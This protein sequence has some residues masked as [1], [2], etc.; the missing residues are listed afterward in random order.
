MS[1][2]AATADTL[3]QL[4]SAVFRE[5]RFADSARRAYLAGKEETLSLSVPRFTL[6]ANSLP[7][8]FATNCHE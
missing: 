7:G 8:G 2:S 5:A 6:H 4:S 1:A 3:L